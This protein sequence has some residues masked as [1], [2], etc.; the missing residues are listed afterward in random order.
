[1]YG[2]K[3]ATRQFGKYLAKLLHEQ[4]FRELVA[5]VCWFVRGNIWILVYADNLFVSYPPSEAK[6]ARQIFLNLNSVMELVDNGTPTHILGVQI[7]YKVHE[8]T[9]RLW[10]A[11]YITGALQRTGMA[12]C[13]AASTPWEAGGEPGP[14][15]TSDGPDASYQVA[16]GLIGWALRV[17]MHLSVG[18]NTLARGQAHTGAKH[19]AMAKRMLRYLAGHKELSLWITRKNQTPTV[20]VYVDSSLGGVATNYKARYGYV[21]LINGN[22]VLSK[23][24][25]HKTVETSTCAAEVLTMAPAMNQAM[26]VC[27]ILGELGWLQKRTRL[28]EDNQGAI[29]VAK[30][31]KSDGRTRHLSL[32]LAAVREAIDNQDFVVEKIAGTDNPADI[33]TKLVGGIVLA[34]HMEK[35]QLR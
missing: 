22:P 25:T 11:E 34:K 33:Y 5:E 19:K 32:R 1:M 4:G 24:S 21:V 26:A 28:Y 29:D 8:G 20:E 17:L 6:D 13:N 2:T 35:L 10:L 14:E 23:A 3:R 18:Y 12:K 9:A 27:N 7:E 31:P 16:V 30:N 15:T